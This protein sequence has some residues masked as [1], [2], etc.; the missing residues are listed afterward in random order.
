MRQK[1]ILILVCALLIGAA[2]VSVAAVVTAQDDPPAEPQTPANLEALAER[3]EQAATRAEEAAED[4][5][6]AVERADA[7]LGHANDLFGLFEAMS[8][9][10]GLV[11]PFLAVVAGIL[12]FRRLENANAELRQAREKFDEELAE[13]NRQL[14]RLNHELEETVRKQR[15][16]TAKASLALALL[17][18]GERQYKAQDYQGALDTYERALALDDRNPIT[19]YRM[20]YVFVHSDQF[21]KAE[22]HLSRSLEL[23]PNFM[24]AVAT[25]GYVY[26]R[27]GDRMPPGLEQDISYN[28]AEEN[29]LAALKVYPKL[30]DEDG[31]SWWGSL[32]GLYRR[33]GQ[34]DQ[35]IYAY[36]QCAAAV[37][38]SSYAY[39]NL[40]LLYGQKQQLDKMI[41]TYQQV[42]RLARGE[43][44]ADVDNYWAY[45]DLVTA[46]LAQGKV[47][48]TWDILDTALNTAPVDSP[49]TLTILAD[50]LVRLRNTLGGD[51][52]ERIDPVLE[53]IRKKQEQRY[54]GGDEDNSDD[55]QDD[56]TENADD[57]AGEEKPAE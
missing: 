20:G 52:Y 21:D 26:R 3:A 12:G 14:D 34:V 25:R 17:Q 4:A 11:I 31:E 46:M 39:S 9:A 1:S 27:K 19:H 45:A 54:G 48:E 8:G 10:V 44:Q 5:E 22:H 33:R 7:A 35:A 40:A 15:E 29:F 47:N 13:R 56:K 24:P 49:Y 41:E 38:R 36:E 42:E 2:L 23:D 6:V 50:T 30:I 57:A 32:G 53:H 37:P 28:K 55:A 43:I 16:E 51:A 18:L